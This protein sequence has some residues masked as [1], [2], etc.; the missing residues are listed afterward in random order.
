MKFPRF[1]AIAI[2]LYAILRTTWDLAVLGSLDLSAISLLEKVAL[3]AVQG[4]LL[5]RILLQSSGRTG[6]PGG[7]AT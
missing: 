2:V 7:T 3:P 6:L 5:W 4:T 1:L